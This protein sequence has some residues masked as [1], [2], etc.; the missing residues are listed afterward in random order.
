MGWVIGFQSGR[1]RVG[2]YGEE[3]S[4][5]ATQEQAGPVL[6]KSR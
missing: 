4:A 5:I 1:V 3:L 6:L 2:R